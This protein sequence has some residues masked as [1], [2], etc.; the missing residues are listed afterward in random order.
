MNRW[1]RTGRRAVA[2]CKLAFGILGAGAA[3]ASFPSTTFAQLCVGFTPNGSASCYLIGTYELREDAVT[4]VHII[5]PTGHTVPVYAFFFDDNQKPLACVH[6]NLS[7][8]D[9]WEISVNKLG[10]QPKA[11]FGVVKV[12]T[13]VNGAVAIQGIVGN[14]RISFGTP[15]AVSETGLHPVQPDLIREDYSKVLSSLVPGCKSM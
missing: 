4:T 8:N 1:F 5:N 7:A 13:F 9:L 11:G 14:Q 3:L 2:T 10:L 12:I 15:R 6:S